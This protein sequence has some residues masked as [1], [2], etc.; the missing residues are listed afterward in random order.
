MTRFDEELSSADVGDSVS[1]YPHS[2]FEYF[3]LPPPRFSTLKPNFARLE[4]QTGELRSCPT[5]NIDKFSTQP[6]KRFRRGVTARESDLE[7]SSRT[8]PDRFNSVAKHNI[9]VEE[10]VSRA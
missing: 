2:S 8:S 5:E 4:V 6:R 10:P 9:S 3:S 7:R 1:W